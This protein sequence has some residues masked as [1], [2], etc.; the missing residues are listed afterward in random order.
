MAKIKKNSKKLII[1]PRIVP[2]GITTEC[3]KSFRVKNHNYICNLK[4]KHINNNTL[5]PTPHEDT[6]RGVKQ[7]IKK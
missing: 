1:Y 7:I 5:K 4:N 6:Y 2:K 3:F